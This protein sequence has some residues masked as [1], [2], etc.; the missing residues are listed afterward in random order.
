MPQRTA[1]ALA[2]R[3]PVSASRIARNRTAC[4][5]DGRFRSRSSMTAC[6]MCLGI[7]I[8]R[9]M[10][11]D[12]F[13]NQYNPKLHNNLIC[14]F[15]AGAT[16]TPVKRGV[17]KTITPTGELD[18]ASA[19][20][21]PNTT[22][23]QVLPEGQITECWDRVKRHHQA[24]GQAFI[25]TVLNGVEIVRLKLM[26]PH[27]QFSNQAKQQIPEIGLRTIRRY[28][29]IGEWYLSA[30]HGD[31]CT[32]RQ[33]RE[34]KAQPQPELCDEQAVQDY[35]EEYELDTAEQLQRHALDKVEALT[36]PGGT[37][38]SRVKNLMKA[39]RRCWSRMS[40]AQR[41]EIMLNFEELKNR[42]ARASSTELSDTKSTAQDEGA[43]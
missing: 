10:L 15:E 22:E 42:P 35:L 14:L 43:S 9:A 3:F 37:P 23:T 21:M 20:S 29:Q 40:A 31:V 19:A 16:P 36:L 39:V 4:A 24:A 32:V 5:A 30:A 17:N 1:I 38:R 41:E 13:F 7:L 2:V 26:L 12:A 28:R 6:V 8:V 25:H 33:L 18:T 11:N 34:K 27:R